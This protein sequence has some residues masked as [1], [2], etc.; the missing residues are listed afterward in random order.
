[1]GT[2]LKRLVLCAV[3]LIIAEAAYCEKYYVDAVNGDNNNS[4]ISATSAWKTLDKVSNSSFKPG[5][6]ILFRAGQVFK[7]TLIVSSGAIGKP[8]IYESYGSG[9]P[10]VIQQRVFR[11]AKPRCY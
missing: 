2:I 8:L 6:K 10:A 5:D 4:G 1:M 7:G 11:A 9:N 3:C